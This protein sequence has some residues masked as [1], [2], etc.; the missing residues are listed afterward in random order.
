MNN[1]D[2]IVHIADAIKELAEIV[3]ER[4]RTGLDSHGI[5]MCE[6]AQLGTMKLG[7]GVI[8]DLSRFAEGLIDDRG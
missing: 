5:V 4:G 7:L 3:V 6:D 8:T 2:K 1:I